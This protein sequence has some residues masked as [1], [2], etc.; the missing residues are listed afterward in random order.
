M[1][2]EDVKEIK[3]MLKAKSEIESSIA[4][5]EKSKAQIISVYCILLFDHCKINCKL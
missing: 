3:E 1:I 4:R 5:E 2:Q